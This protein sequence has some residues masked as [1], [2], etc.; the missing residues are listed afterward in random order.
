MGL[1]SFFK[2]PAAKASA[3]GDTA[4]AV[5]AARTT[6][7]R[8]LIGAVLLLGIGVIAFPLLFETQ[9]RPLP[10]DIPIEIPKKDGLAPLAMP[11]PRPAAPE[12]SAASPSPK[13]ATPAPTMITETKAEAGKEVPAP[14]ESAA[15]TSAKP[16]PATK[17]EP[18]AKAVASKPAPVP[19][20]PAAENKAGGEVPGR[21]VVQVGAFADSSGAREA[22][23]KV[24]KLGL[25]TYTQAVETD[26]G[27][28]TRV[29]LGPFSSRDDAEKA[30][31]KLK[32][33]GLPAA[34]LTL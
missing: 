23:A 15:K 12:A 34:V 19:A 14:T 13:A 6:A 21:F 30:A 20:A 16:E 29:R 26:K 28:R 22:R 10:V 11:A 9:P 1:F 25:K 32:A 3:G 17:P 18:T 24:E 8:R 7:R 5:D 4:Q 33:A 31:A 27:T 2:R